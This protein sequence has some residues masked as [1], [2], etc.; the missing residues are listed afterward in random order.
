VVR[1]GGDEFV[2]ILEDVADADAAASVAE[3][4]LR[5][6]ALPIPLDNGASVCVGASIG[7]SICPDDA[8]EIDRLLHHAD[9][10]MYRSKLDGRN[11]FTL[12]CDTGPAVSTAQWINFDAV[13]E[14]GIAVLDQQHNKLVRLAGALNDAVI[15]QKPAPMVARLFEEFMQFLQFHFRTEEGMMEKCAY[16]D[17][18]HHQGMHRGLLEDI[19]HIR[20]HITHGAETVALQA[21]KDWL[22]HHVHSADLPAA[23]FMLRDA[24][25][26]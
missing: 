26:N 3:K 10:A 13:A 17:R 22:V 19:A 20:G 1:A 6:V 21:I 4:A 25:I 2:V 18:E 24:G 23:G 5:S 8:Q 15:T 7:V 16:P 11:R 9:Q 14:V 12:F